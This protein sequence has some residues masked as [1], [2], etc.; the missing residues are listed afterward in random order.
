MSSL[1]RSEYELYDCEL[2]VR[3]RANSSHPKEEKR[4]TLTACEE[5]SIEQPRGLTSN[6]LAPSQA[7][8]HSHYVYYNDVCRSVRITNSAARTPLHALV[9]PTRDAWP[10]HRTT[11]STPSASRPSAASQPPVALTNPLLIRT[12]RAARKGPRR[13]TRPESYPASRS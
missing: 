11:S 10:S 8:S 9:P 13:G 12:M 5:S 1:K 3:V 2:R 6:S 4:L 7:T